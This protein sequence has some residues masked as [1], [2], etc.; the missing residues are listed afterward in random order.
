MLNQLVMV[1]DGA[2]MLALDLFWYSEVFYN[3]HRLHSSLG[4]H[5][6]AV[7]LAQWR[8]DNPSIHQTQT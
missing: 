2:T 3:R 5:I 7:Y 1:P 8:H 6:A 4:Y